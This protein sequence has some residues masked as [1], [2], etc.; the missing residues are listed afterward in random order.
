VTTDITASFN[1]VFAELKRFGFLL[2]S[3]QKLPSVCS[4]IAGETMRGSWWSHPKANTIFHVNERLDDHEDVLITKLVSGKV[5]FVHREL[6][7]ALF[8]V[9][10]AKQSWQ[11]DRLSPA[12]KD[13]FQTVETERRVRTDELPWSH[14]SKVGDAARDL[15]KRLLV[16]AEQIHTESGAHARVLESWNGWKQK[17]GLNKAKMSVEDAMSE[18]EARVSR[19]NNEFDAKASLPWSVFTPHA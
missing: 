14:K 12:A 6:W 2:E 3:D 5:T 11:L 15:E 10:D 16:V 8:T 13:L 18:F 9:G 4:I 17:A 7:P 1:Q 19:L